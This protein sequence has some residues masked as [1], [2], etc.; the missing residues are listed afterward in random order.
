M[1]VFDV[2]VIGAGVHGAS[3]A[4]HLASRGV[5]TVV[6][7]REAPALG[8]T[9]RSSG[10]CRAYYTNPFLARVAR[11]SIDMLKRFTE[12]TG[13]HDAGFHPTGF[14][15]LQQ[16]DELD[17]VREVLGHLNAIGTVTEIL[18]LEA[19]AERFPAIDRTSIGFGV[20]ER[21]AGYADPAATTTEFFRRAVELGAEARLGHAVTAIEHGGVQGAVVTADGERTRCSRILIAAGPWTG[22][23]VKHV[24]VEL[25]LTVERHFVAVFRWGRADPVVAHADIA[26]GYYFRPEGSEQFLLGSLHPADQVD[27]DAFPEDAGEREVLELAE[28]LLRRVPDLVR[29]EPQGGWASLYDVSPDWQP[30]IGEIAP[31]V[32]VDAGT[33]GHGFKLAPALGR[34]VAD[35]VVGDAVDPG[36]RDFD[37]FRFASGTELPAGFGRSRILG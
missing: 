33:S 3:A 20:W 21:D 10:I 17:R 6:F 22:P 29:S 28:P 14:L 12:I 15:F 24:G 4:F 5:R 19:L 16:E 9:G 13:G 32:F 30:V 2:A 27:P 7:E 25:P 23:L 18:D 11:E 37:P 26:A 35:L 36:L 34:H 1:E 31:G 8:P